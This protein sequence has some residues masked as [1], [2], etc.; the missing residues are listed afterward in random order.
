MKT[1][2]I[3]RKY[4]RLIVSK[5]EALRETSTQRKALITWALKF[6]RLAIR[7]SQARIAEEIHHKRVTESCYLKWR[8][9]FINVAKV[10]LHFDDSYRNDCWRRPARGFSEQ[11][12]CL[13]T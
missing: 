10:S 1:N 4:E 12:S 9:T 2:K 13:S 8:H 11:S 7:R 3:Q 5:F 6:K